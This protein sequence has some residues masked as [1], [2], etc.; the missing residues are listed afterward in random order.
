VVESMLGKKYSG[1]LISDFLAT[2]NRII[3]RKQRCLVHLLR[4]IKK[5]LVYFESDKKK[6]KYFLQLKALVKDILELSH[7]V[8]MTL[9]QLTPLTFFHQLL[10][11]P[12]AAA[13]AILPK[14]ASMG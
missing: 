12:T 6:T 9:H 3:C 13:A 5:Q 8:L 7:Q 1:V 14:T 2:Y 4:L 11:D 10:T